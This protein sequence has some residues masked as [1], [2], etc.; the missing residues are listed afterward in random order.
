MSA[1][2]LPPRSALFVGY[3]V[4]LPSGDREQV[5]VAGWPAPHAEVDLVGLASRWL[6]DA[7]LVEDG[8]PLLVEAAVVIVGFRRVGQAQVGELRRQAPH[9]EQD[10]ALDLRILGHVVERGALRHDELEPE[11]AHAHGMPELEE[12]GGHAACPCGIEGDG[13]F[14]GLQTHQDSFEPQRGVVAEQDPSPVVDLFELI[15]VHLLQPSGWLFT[16]PSPRSA[17]LDMGPFH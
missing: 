5:G 10:G 2:E 4:Q 14:R 9:A 8:R 12:S 3:L 13:A 17:W 16:V 7:Q 11:V 15:P 1:P 6:A